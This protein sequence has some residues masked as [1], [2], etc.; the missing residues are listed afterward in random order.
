VA[1]G[2]N[3]T[4]LNTCEIYNPA[5][6]TWSGTGVMTGQRSFHT[7]TLLPNGKVLAAAGISGGAYLK[8]SELFNPAN[9]IWSS[10]GL[11]SYQRALPGTALLPNGLVLV[12]GGYNG[13]YLPSV[14]RYDFRT[15]TWTLGA[16]NL[17][18]ARS[19]DSAT[20]LPG[21]GKVLIAGGQNG[22]SYLN[23]AELYSQ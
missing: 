9:G 11:M 1:C 3:V 13:S 19:G 16:G 23:T 5:N 2:Q 18:T 10:S 14:E 7:A 6:N 21:S 20:W 22:S 12:V 15:G 4:D 17:S 8:T